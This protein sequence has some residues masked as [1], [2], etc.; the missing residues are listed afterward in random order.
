MSKNNKNL[1]H[2]DEYNLT[3]EQLDTLKELGNI[4]SGNAITA[5]SKLLNREVVVSLTSV[6]IIPFWKV[7]E[8]F[9]SPHVEVFGVYSEVPFNSELSI[10]QMFTK[11]SL[12]NLINLLNFNEEISYEQ[13]KKVEDLDDLSVSIIKEIGNILTGHYT[14]ALAD[15]LSTQLIPNVPTVA[16]DTLNAIFNGIIAKHSRLSDFLIIIKTKIT[17]PEINL[18][19]IMCFIPCINILKNFFKILN[20]KYDMNL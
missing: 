14:S 7:Q 9:E 18:N 19:C 6:D 5:L 11:K 10:I 2:Q 12:I 16:L 20:L 8:S 15:L 3:P 17:L 1:Q 4:G 13:I